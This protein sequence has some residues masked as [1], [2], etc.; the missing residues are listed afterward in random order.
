MSFFEGALSYK[1]LCHMPLPEIAML[2]EDAR[3]IHAA[4]NKK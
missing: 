2:Q 4:R 3:R 1:E